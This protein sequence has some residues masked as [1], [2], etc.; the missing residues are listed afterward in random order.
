MQRGR[1]SSANAKTS[2]QRSAGERSFVLLVTGVFAGVM[3]AVAGMQA[4]IA[5]QQSK[6]RAAIGQSLEQV[7]R[8]QSSYRLVHGKFATW[9]ELQARGEQI[10]AGLEV[11]RSNATTSHWYMQLLDRHSGLVCDRIH[12]LNAEWNEEPNAERCREVTTE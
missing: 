12:D 7:S 5:Y 4:K 11:V 8:H 2:P 6:S 3:I 1:P 10:A 9:P